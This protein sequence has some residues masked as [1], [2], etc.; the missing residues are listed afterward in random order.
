RRFLLHDR[1]ISEDDADELESHLRDEVEELTAEGRTVEEAFE[2]A[3]RRVGDIGTLEGAYRGVVWTKR[4]HDHQIRREFG[5]RLTMLTNYLKTALRNARRQKGYTFINIVGLSIGLACSFFI[6]LWVMNEVSFDR[7]HKDGDRIYRVLR[8][9]TNNGVVFTRRAAPGP[10]ADALKKGFPEIENATYSWGGQHFLITRGEDS[11][12]EEGTYAGADFFEVFTFPLLQGDPAT[13]LQVEN[14][15]VISEKLAAKLFGKDWRKGNVIGKTINI[16]HDEDFTITAVAAD[17]PDNSTIRFDVVLPIQEYF[18]ENEWALHWGSNAFPLCVRLRKGASLVDVNA[19]IADILEK[20]SPDEQDEVVFLQPI[21]D[22][23][24]YGKF[25]NGVNTGGRI[26]LIRIFTVV[27]LF[28]L[29]IASINFM[30]L[31][32]ARSAQRSK[33]IGV[34]KAIGATQ[35]SLAGQFLAETMLLACA[36][37]VLALLLVVA[38]LPVFN[39]LTGKHVGVTDL[40]PTFLLGVLGIALLTGL[41]AGSYPALYLS[42][43]SPVAN[44]RGTFRQKPGAA[45]LRKGLVVFQFGLSTLIIVST[46]AVYFQIQ[47][48]MKKDLGLDRGNLVTFRLEGGIREQYEAFR[49]ELMKKPGIVNVT[50]SWGNPLMVSSSTSSATWEGKDPN[51]QTEFGIIRVGY[52]FIETMKMEMAAGRTPARQFGADSAGYIINEQAAK[53]MG[54][55]NPVGEKLE[56]WGPPGQ[57]IGV[58]KDFHTATFDAPISPV[59]FVLMPDA[60]NQGWVRTEPGRTAEALAGLEA[61]YKQ[62]NPGYPFEYEFLDK[63]YEGMYRSVIMMGKL[64]DVFAVIAIFISCLGLFGLASFTAEQRTKE[65]GVRKVLGASASNLVMLLSADFTKLVLLGFVLGA[66]LAYWLIQKY[67]DTYA[68]HVSITPLMFVGAGVAA[69]VIAWLTV[70]YQSIRAALANPVESLRSE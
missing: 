52:D 14:S 57:V 16:D 3:V 19:K 10:M 8:N 53:A 67:L 33:E 21:E 27:A 24:L 31:A 69:L 58:V 1:A 25:E 5:W 47:Y 56:A 20:N 46:A 43:F 61:V 59:I 9:E 65:I 15:A 17:V 29:L 26:E 2:M 42:S 50:T 39:T 35:R 44:L 41:F 54:K 66:P 51:D 48:I 63:E 12:R 18:A 37:F 70:S 68:Y 30:N 7:F 22:V 6:L 4:L 62:F 23:H 28:L 11:F 34:R 45:V 32:T 13:A 55:A 49:H 64:A 60:T 36:A 38:L 40:S